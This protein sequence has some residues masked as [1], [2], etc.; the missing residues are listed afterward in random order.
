M[1]I[2]LLILLAVAETAA[3]SPRQ[4]WATKDGVVALTP[5]GERLAVD[6]PVGREG[7]REAFARWGIAYDEGQLAVIR[8]LFTPDA[9][10]AVLRGSKEPIASADGVE[11]ILANV[12]SAQKQQDDQRRHA[13]SNIVITRMSRTQATAVAYGIVTI[14]KDGLSLGATV[15]YSADLV[16]GADGAWRF[17]R[18]TIG[19]DDYAGRA[20]VNPD[21]PGR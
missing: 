10:F 21:A 8:S 7:I 5:Q 14:A 19:M 12:S 1:R 3:S 18:F 2:P 20:I 11:A 4:G 16:H 17:S 6:D 13:I 15:I 9:K